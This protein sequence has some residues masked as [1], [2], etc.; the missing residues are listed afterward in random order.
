VLPI[1]SSSCERLSSQNRLNELL[2]S[3]A[4]N[5]L[6]FQKILSWA[7]GEANGKLLAQIVRSQ[8][9]PTH[10]SA[11]MNVE[12]EVC[13][14]TSS[15]ISIFKSY[16]QDLYTSS[17]DFTLA[18]LSSYMASI[19]LPAITIEEREILNALMPRPQGPMVS[20]LRP[21]ENII[22]NCFPHFLAH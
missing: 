8:S 3:R 20:L 21:I 11:L 4:R 10:V 15:T 22:K 18:E 19:D 13:N 16:Y 7:E 9:N 2:E 17:V 12:G 1:E 5:K 6:F 14:Q